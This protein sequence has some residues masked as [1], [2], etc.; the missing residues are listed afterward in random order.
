MSVIQQ[1]QIKPCEVSL[2]IE[3]DEGKVGKAF[4]QAYREIGSEITVPGFRKGKAPKSILQKHVSQ[5][6]VK[7]IAAEILVE[8][9]IYDAIDEA[10]IEP[11]GAPEFEVLH[12]EEGEP[13]RFK[14]IVPLPPKV[15]LGEYVG[16]EVER[17]APIVDD[18][19]VENAI[20]R[21]RSEQVKVSDAGDRPIQKG[22][23]VHLSIASGSGGSVE[24]V[25][26]VG[27]Q[28]QGFDEGL[29]GMKV[30]E[31]KTIEF[32]YPDDYEDEEVAG[33]KVSLTVAIHNIKSRELPALTDEW[34]RE[35]FS[36]NPDISNVED[37]RSHIRA[38]L[39]RYASTMADRAVEMSLIK[40]V[41]ESSKIDYPDALLEA[42][43]DLRVKSLA[44][45][46]ENRGYTLEDYLRVTRKTEDQLVTEI[47]EEAR[48]DLER[49]LIIREIA[50]RENIEVGRE[51]L[52]AEVAR[53]AED[54]GVP[55]ES[56]RAYLDAKD[57]WSMLEGRLRRRKVLDFLV[58]ASNIRNVGRE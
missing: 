29:I 15:E 49:Y 5:E 42:E 6:R 1:E 33:K 55:V 14:A 17:L 13:F 47:R 31:S 19:D 26:I 24:R 34:V 23:L 51:D 12:I 54:Q 39:E 43:V 20:E 7:S 25:V 11:F 32:E 36:N 53:I 3:V 21:L 2:E 22:D 40:K 44:S 8:S 58:Q 30:G 4:D 57:E 48:D 50:I 41:V 27:E 28:V 9:N 45:D 38:D 56:V 16:L 18:K 35:S 52:D 37:L 10:G 46:L